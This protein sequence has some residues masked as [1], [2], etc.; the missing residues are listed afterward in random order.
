M[1]H[2]PALDTFFA[3]CQ[4]LL[5]SMESVLL[6][7]EQGDADPEAINEL[8]RAAHTIKGSAG[9]FGLDSIVA[10]THVVE[11]VLDRARANRSPIGAALAAAL[12]ECRDHIQKLVDLTAT[13]E[14]AE[15]AA[16]RALGATV[17]E[18]LL[19]ASGFAV[20]APASAPAK[21]VAPAAEIVI[22]D[23]SLRI[24]AN[25][26]HI[27]VRFATTIL[28]N[29][30]DPLSFCR[31]LTTFGAITGL[32]IVDD[33]L[34]T[35]AD[36]DA[37]DC[38]LGFEIGFETAADKS[39]IES[40]FEFVRDDCRLRILPPRARISDFIALIRD[41]PE[42]DGRLGDL[43]VKCG[44]L[45]AREL[46][47]C[48]KLQEERS[49]E[50]GGAPKIGEILI[51]GHLVQPSV[52][53]AAVQ[54]QGE[55]RATKEAKTQESRTIRVDGDKLDRL[56]DLIGELVIAGAATGSTARQAGLP[57]LNESALQLAGIVEEV[58]DQALK[59]RMVQIGA[60]FTRFQRVV[61][62]VARETG[63]DIALETTGAETELDR[64]LVEG[65]ADPLTH[66]VRN[67]ID[68][69]IEKPEVREARGKPV[70]GV[71]SL[72]AHH[73]AGSVVIEIADD[74][75][76]LNRER[77]LEKAIERGLIDATRSLT[78]GEIY[79]LIFEPGFSTAEKVTNLSG[80]GV[81]M[82]VVKRNITAL[83]GTVEV[84]SEPGLGTRVRIRLP[85]T[86]AIIDGFQVGVGR[87]SFV[88]PLNL[89]EECVD[90]DAGA[91]ENAGHINLR[92]SVLPLI[93]LR[94]M[95]AIEGAASRRQSVVV[96][97][98]AGK[99]VGIVVDELVGE[100]QAVI[101]P[102][103]KLFSQ[104]RGIGGSTILGTGRVALILDVPGLVELS[105]TPT[106]AGSGAR[107]RLPQ[108][109][110]QVCN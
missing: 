74:G 80:R 90:V 24:E 5:G 106:A 70:T 72:S 101:K 34:P 30:M 48:L 16:V 50:A 61:R 77:I 19:A 31:Y 42:A 20:T 12:L 65:M 105:Q 56:I 102:L 88:I 96:V 85:L 7:C 36:F 91:D 93:R 110:A 10:F 67:A 95:F 108:A 14:N 40:A 28:K 82:D 75:G 104:L 27:S 76:G 45:T 100:L 46:A 53:A 43:L 21:A 99:S 1:S 4:E 94:T 49:S 39:R 25:S 26:W 69:G 84:Q 41:L 33:A 3:E 6:R 103:S 97:R 83:R 47:S 78:D 55:A 11:S 109:S 62:D 23:D 81:G 71:V 52:V 60:T 35:L 98:G 89:V 9:L 58:R 22:G 57:A 54:Q 79:A 8:F 107:P 68:H 64:Q 44:T 29:G 86:L 63:K 32:Q 87:S 13:G 59:L 51:E 92:G 37:E 18:H 15:D 2:D 73:E 66:L 17:H 38:Y